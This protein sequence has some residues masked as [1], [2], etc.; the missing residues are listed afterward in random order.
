MLEGERKKERRYEMDR[1]DQG[2]THGNVCLLISKIQEFEN[3]KLLY[4]HRK[5]DHGTKFKC[6]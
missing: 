1:Y 4:E 6:S 2:K 3:H 5:F